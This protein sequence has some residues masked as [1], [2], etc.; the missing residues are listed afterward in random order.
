MNLFINT[1]S[2]DAHIIL[3]DDN[4][5]ISDKIIFEIKGNESSLLIPTLDSFLKKNNLKY[6]EIKNIVL[7]NGPGSFTGV[8]TVVL[9]INSIN[10]ITNNNLTAISYF[11][12]FKNYPIVKSSS[13]RD[14]FFKEN[15]EN[16]IE[17]ILNEDLQNYLKQKNLSTIYGEADIENVEII[18]NIDYLSII[19]EIRFDN[20]KKIEPL[21]IK[22]PNIC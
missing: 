17:I 13:K 16:N 3:F 14:C 20:L 10:Y 21:Y 15:Q 1:I 5:M 6:D 2:K 9:A 18:E 11:D 22:K 8:R 12:L 7:V 19:A 4:R